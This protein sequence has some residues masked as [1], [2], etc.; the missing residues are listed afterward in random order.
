M[1]WNCHQL[2]HIQIICTSLQTDNHA[3]TPPLSFFTGQM[4]FLLPNQQHQSTKG[5][6]IVNNN[7]S[8]NMPLPVQLIN[9]SAYWSP[10]DRK[11]SNRR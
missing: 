7:Y 2:D 9:A 11:Q 10:K 1:G 4:P 5:L 3:S 6:V 8:V